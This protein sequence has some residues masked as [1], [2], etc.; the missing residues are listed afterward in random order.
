MTPM[1]PSLLSINQIIWG[2]YSALFILGFFFMKLYIS[3]LA[4]DIVKME[5]QM[6]A[7]IT[8]M[9]NQLNKKLDSLICVER[10]DSVKLQ[11]RIMSKHKH[12]PVT[13]GGSGGEVILP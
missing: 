11:C 4:K 6:A 3:S 5:E 10:N 1:P 9:E 2:I 12:A 13:A 7:N 8:R